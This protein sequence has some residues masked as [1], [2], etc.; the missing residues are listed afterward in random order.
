MLFPTL[1]DQAPVLSEDSLAMDIKE[2][3]RGQDN[4]PHSDQNARPDDT[5]LALELEPQLAHNIDHQEGD[6]GKYEWFDPQ[7]DSGSDPGKAQQQNGD[8]LQQTWIL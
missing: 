5:A 8:E 1:V 6:S 3:H 7:P 2:D 4:Q